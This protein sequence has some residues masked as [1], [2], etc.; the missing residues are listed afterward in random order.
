M[1]SI[2]WKTAL[3]IILVITAVVSLVNWLFSDQ[4]FTFQFVVDCIGKSVSLITL[5]SGLFCTRLWKCRIFQKW[6]VLI[7]N[8]NG[9]WEGGIESTWIDPKTNE[10]KSAI[11]AILIVNQS[12][13]KTSCL[14][15]TDESMSR[16]ITANFVI[17]KENQVCKL[18]YTYQNDSNQTLREKSPIH[19]GTAAL[20]I[21]E[22][23][24]KILL[25]GN[26]WTDR[27]TNGYLSFCSQT[28]KNK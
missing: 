27:K 2:R 22:R 11:P 3:Y 5:L 28:D 15:K 23:N 4:I 21:Q 20:D 12:L 8:L 7:P 16:S 13:F 18:V 9:L 17:D 25:C 19:Y 26:Y 14:I 6:L 10:K 24:G 1:N